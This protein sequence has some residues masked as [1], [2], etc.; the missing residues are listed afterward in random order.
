MAHGSV[1]CVESRTGA[2]APRGRHRAP[3]EHRAP[4]INY[5]GALFHCKF[6]NPASVTHITRRLGLPEALFY[7]LYGMLAMDPTGRSLSVRR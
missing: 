3:L 5:T 1:G 6:A 2:P 7:T 4:T